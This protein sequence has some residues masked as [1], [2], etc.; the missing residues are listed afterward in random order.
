[1]KRYLVASSLL[2][3]SFTSPVFAEEST[4]FYLSFGGGLNSIS[5]LEGDLGTDGFSFDTNSPFQYSL[6]IG[7]E[8]DDWRLEFNYSGSTVSMDSVTVTP[9][10]QNSVSVD[11]VP[12]IEAD[13][14]SY[15]LYGLK[16]LTNDTKF[17]T[18]LGAGVG[19]T[20]LD[21]PAQNIN[22]GGANVPLPAA[23]EQVFSFGVKGGVEYEIAENTSL[24]SEIG[25]LN[26][27]SF[28]GVDDESYDSL[29][30]FTVGGGLRF[31][32]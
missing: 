8:F 19:F 23:D 24:F 14:T 7:K 30:S 32:F 3:C 12:E 9:A 1:M 2:L 29:N 21:L 16:N 26:L 5:D 15:M 25:Y 20:S 22:V 27:S 11:L 13:V 10:G 28:D 17:T 6:A 31:N 18:Y 4:G